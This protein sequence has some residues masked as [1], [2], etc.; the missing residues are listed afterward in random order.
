M[1]FSAINHSNNL[2]PFPILFMYISAETSLLLFRMLTLLPLFVF[3]K[4]KK[5]E[6]SNFVKDKDQVVAKKCFLKDVFKAIFLEEFFMEMQHVK[7]FD[8][9]KFYSTFY[10]ACRM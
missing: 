5:Y 4:T 2:F 9:N 6:L 1:T 8:G 7:Q 3:S 10:L